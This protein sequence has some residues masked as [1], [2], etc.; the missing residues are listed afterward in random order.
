M[1]QLSLISFPRVKGEW[2][3]GSS[4]SDD[5]LVNNVFNLAYVEN[6]LSVSASHFQQMPFQGRGDLYRCVPSVKRI[7]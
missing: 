4:H 1:E 3:C 7:T 2:P 5:T 6:A